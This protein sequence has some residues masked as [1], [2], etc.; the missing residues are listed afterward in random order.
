M[1]CTTDKASFQEHHGDIHQKSLDVYTHFGYNASDTTKGPVRISN[2]IPKLLMAQ[3]HSA[4]H[5]IK[6]GSLLQTLALYSK[7]SRSI[8]TTQTTVHR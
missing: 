3:G 5:P 4:E 7:S 8:T 1:H 6:C 2:P